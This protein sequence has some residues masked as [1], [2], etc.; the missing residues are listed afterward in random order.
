MNIFVSL[1]FQNI[2]DFLGNIELPRNTLVVY[3]SARRFKSFQSKTDG[4]WLIA[5]MKEV[6]DE[7]RDDSMNDFNFMHLIV[8]ATEKVSKRESDVSKKVNTTANLSD[9]TKEQEYTTVV[10]EAKSGK[11]NAVTTYHR[12]LQ[13]LIF[14]LSYEAYVKQ[15]TVVDE[16]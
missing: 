11:K 9:K 7:Y 13:P 8:K 6:I 4:Y 15:T 14:R 3:Q 16:A 1:I 12:L 2:D 10:D 5:A